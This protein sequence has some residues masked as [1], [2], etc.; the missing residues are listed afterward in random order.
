ME[1]AEVNALAQTIAANLARVIGP[2]F[3]SALREEITNRRLPRYSETTGD[4]FD[5]AARGTPLFKENGERRA[6]LIQNTSAD[7]DLFLSFTGLAG[8]RHLTL[9]PGASFAEHR[10]PPGNEIW[11]NAS[12]PDCAFY[13]YEG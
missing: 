5:Y 1:P 3:G 7:R 12:G 2:A 11:I 6:I 10:E 13:A 9:G 4:A 8:A